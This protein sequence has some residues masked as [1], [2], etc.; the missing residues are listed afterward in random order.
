M[1][2]V[3][4]DQSADAE[5]LAH[6]RTFFAFERLVL[7]AAMHV[8]LI[9][10]SLALGLIGHIPVIATFLGVGGTIALI[11]AFAVMGSQSDI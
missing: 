3:E 9:L 1:S 4:L 5:V 6:R 10:S 11:V 7:F 8:A 2:V